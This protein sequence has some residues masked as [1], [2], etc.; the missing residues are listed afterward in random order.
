MGLDDP[1]PP[2]IV[3]SLIIWSKSFRRLPGQMQLS[4]ELNSKAVNRYRME[5]RCPIF[6][7]EQVR[8]FGK[9]DH[10]QGRLLV[11]YPF[12]KRSPF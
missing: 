5:P 3:I 6:S 2:G 10:G 8:W 7:M 1:R 9:E 4:K 12:L 11:R